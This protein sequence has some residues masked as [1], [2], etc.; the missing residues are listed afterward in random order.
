MTPQRTEEM[1]RNLEAAK[2]LP[3]GQRLDVIAREFARY[4]ADLDE[5]SRQV[6]AFLER[7]REAR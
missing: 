2:S 7:Q 3:L 5:H 4:S 1:R 6:D